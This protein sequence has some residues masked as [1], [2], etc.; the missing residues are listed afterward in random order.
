MSR[1]FVTGDVHGYLDIDKLVVFEQNMGD[2]LTRND[3]MIVLGDF[4]LPFCP[5]D[6]DEYKDGVGE[7]YYWINWLENQKYTTLFID[8]NHDFHS[9]WA[10]QP[11]IE[12]FGGKVQVHPHAPHVIHLMRGQ[13]YNIDGK[14]F[15]TM[16]GAM[17]VDKVYRIEGYSWWKEEMPSK[18]EYEEAMANLDKVHFNV[19]YVLTHCCGTQLLQRL[20][21]MHPN[22]D[23]L[24]QFFWHL[25]KDFGLEFKHWYFGHHHTDT[26]IGNHTCLYNKVVRI[27]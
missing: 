16:G 24:T 8:G 23:E 7:Y 22:P 19:D 15:F 25:E 21:S 10:Q 6:L 14:S 17:S 13:V 3:Y 4:G 5:A 26:T 11:V 12:M 1:I 2:T 20:Y 27:K 9:W 18:E